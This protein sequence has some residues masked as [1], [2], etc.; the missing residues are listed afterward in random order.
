MNLED[1]LYFTFFSWNLLAV[2]FNSIISIATEYA[3]T[4]L[5]SVYKCMCCRTIMTTI[6]T[7]M[8]IYIYTYIHT[9]IH[10]YIYIYIYI[11]IYDSEI[12]HHNPC[13]N[14]LILHK[15]SFDNQWSEINKNDIFYVSTYCLLQKLS[16]YYIYI[17][18]YVY[19]YIYPNDRKIVKL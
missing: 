11:Y 10:T 13:F 9:Y 3:F 12:V 5:I 7:A 14:L 18:M 17:Y 19:I 8:T 2:T 16:S 1:D 15:N 6:M 4:L